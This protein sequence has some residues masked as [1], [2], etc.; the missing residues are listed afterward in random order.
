MLRELTEL[1]LAV[2]FGLSR[3]D[4]IARIAPFADGVVVGSAIVDAY[5]GLRGAEAARAVRAFVDPLIGATA[6][7][8]REAERF[9]D[10]AGDDAGTALLRAVGPPG[11]ASTRRRALRP[12]AKALARAASR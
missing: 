5:A 6:L 2:G 12:P 1:P 7:G 8:Q 3:A 10:V 11:R 9:D 4:A